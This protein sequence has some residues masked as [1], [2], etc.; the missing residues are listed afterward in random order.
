MFGHHFISYSRAD[1]K[2]FAIQLH[3]ALLAEPLSFRA[4]LDVLELNAG[5]DDWDEQVVE[6][7]RTCESLIFV[8]TLDSVESYSVC[9]EEWTRALSYKKPVIPLRVHPEAEIPFR[10]QSRQYIDFTGPFDAALAKLCNNLRWL[11]SPEGKLQAIKH[12]L[13]HD[14]ATSW[15]MERCS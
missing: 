4:W 2:H 12:R 6:A 15:E 13:V 7:I 10:L 1:A 9:K 3:D 5:I 8:M 14:Q 11:A